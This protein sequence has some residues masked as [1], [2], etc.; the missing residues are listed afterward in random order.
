MGL[1]SPFPKLVK[2]I[3][4]KHHGYTQLSARR[5]LV[6]RHGPSARLQG[7]AIVAGY[8][9]PVQRSDYGRRD[10]RFDFG[11]RDPR[12]C[13][14]PPRVS[15]ELVSLAHPT[16]PD[17]RLAKFPILPHTHKFRCRRPGPA[18]AYLASHSTARG[19]IINQEFK[20]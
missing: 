17:M 5:L 11:R 10:P 1:F 7:V 3:P 2:F 8:E 9:P 19:G 16:D 12:F 6:L 4:S 20:G 13:W 15:L 14:T 18:P